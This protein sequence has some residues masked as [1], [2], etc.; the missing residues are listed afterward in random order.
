MDVWVPYA[1][2]STFKTRREVVIAEFY[3][4]PECYMILGIMFRRKDVKSD[5]TLICEA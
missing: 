1:G 4:C 3:L 2:S 5:R